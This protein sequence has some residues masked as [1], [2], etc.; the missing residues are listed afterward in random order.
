MSL[1]AAAFLDKGGVGKTTATAQFG[2]CAN[3]LGYKTLLIDLAGKQNDLAKHF[4]L[5]EGLETPSDRFPN[6]AKV[7]ADDWE[8]LAETVPDVV[9]RMI[10]E[11][12]EGVD[13][14]PAHP[15]LDKTDND[16]A[17]VPVEDRVTRLNEFLDEHVDPLGYDL[18]LM[19][20]PGLTN[21]I[22]FNGLV[23]AESVFAPA[24][25]G[26]FERE[27]L[28]ALKNDI[29]EARD[30]LNT[31]I[32]LTMVIPNRVNART[33]VGKK[34][35][36]DMQEAYPDRVAPEPVPES[37]DFKNAQDVGKTIFSLEEPLNTGER[38][39]TAYRANTREL[40]SRLET[41]GVEA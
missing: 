41:R 22:T 38:A 35:L 10:Y 30:K 1:R 34:M 21:N 13:L 11:T 20:L 26:K 14:I 23:A 15:A 33:K 9:D 37:Q 3:D 6:I 24:E 19:D 36:E 25:M 5:Y 29:E 8:Q 40:L 18:I 12:E 27:Q 32:D 31:N 7:F 16:L 2:R 39:R 28:D 17:S 4:G